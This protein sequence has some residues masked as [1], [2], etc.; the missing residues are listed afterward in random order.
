MTND[1][2]CSASLTQSQKPSV[3][4]INRPGSQQIAPDLKFHDAR[5]VSNGGRPCR[6]AA[7]GAA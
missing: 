4:S 6:G 5:L 7:Q 3:Q 1:A 2:S